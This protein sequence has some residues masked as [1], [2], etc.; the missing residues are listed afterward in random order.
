MVED[1][2]TRNSRPAQK[3]AMIDRVS[4]FVGQRLPNLERQ[5]QQAVWNGVLLLSIGIVLSVLGIS[6]RQDVVR[7]GWG[8]RSLTGF[9]HEIG[10]AYEA[11]LHTMQFSGH[12]HSSPAVVLENGRPLGPGNAQHDDVRKQGGG[13]FSFWG[14]WVYVSTS[15]NSDPRSNGRTYVAYGPGILST[16]VRRMTYASALT[17]LFLAAVCITIGLRDWRIPDTDRGWRSALRQELRRDASP[18]MPVVAVVGAFGVATTVAAIY[19]SVYYPVSILTTAVHVQ[20]HVIARLLLACGGY[21]IARATATRRG[22]GQAAVS[23]SI[24]AI[25]AIALLCHPQSGVGLDRHLLLQTDIEVFVLIGIALG[26]LRASKSGG[27]IG[28][29]KDSR[30]SRGAVVIASMALAIPGIALPVVNWW[31]IS[32]YMDSQMYD[33]D[34][35]R[36]ALGTALEGDSFVMPLY[37][38]GMAALYFVFGHFFYVQQIANVVLTLAAVV[39]L[40]LAAFELF[41][42][43]RAAL[44]MGVL[45]ALTPQFSSFVKITQVENWY[46]PLIALILYLWT[47]Y[48]NHPTMGRAVALAVAVGL[49]FN[50]RSQGTFFFGM[51]CLAPMW[52]PRVAVRRKLFQSAA[53]FVIVGLTLVPWSLRNYLYE[54]H[55][56]PSSDQATIGLLFNDHRVGFYGIRWDLYGWQQV[57]KEYEQR[58]PDKTERFAAIRHD[59]IGNTFGDPAWLARA[60]SWRTLSFYGLLPPGV[61][62]ASGP[63]PTNW[64]SEWPSYVY[65]GI[66]PLSL[67]AISMIGALR[68]LN[69]DTAFLAVCILATLAVMVFASQREA[70]ISYPV[71][72]L[73]IML[74]LAAMFPLSDRSTL[75]P[76]RIIG[77]RRLDWRIFAIGFG[78]LL[79]VCG[80]ARLS[81]GR[82][83]ANRPLMEHAMLVSESAFQEHRVRSPSY[84]DVNIEETLHGAT[85]VAGDAVRIRCRLTNYMLPPKSAGAVDYLP[86]YVSDP[87]REQYFFAH[88]VDGRRYL[89]ITYF[90]AVAKEVLRENDLVIV[91]GHV[92]AGDPSPVINLAFWLRADAV[93]KE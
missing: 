52:Q 14:D 16:V 30:V 88:T 39:L 20:V 83:N 25:V 91:E 6:L 37:Q 10:Y 36:I 67:I 75:V 92:L 23:A 26:L 66:V 29:W 8:Q 81:V 63:V 93:F 64:Q 82:E 86:A 55:F 84:R 89:G 90:G 77:E 22:F 48:R 19:L 41:R 27:R 58:I 3:H 47:R 53:M 45:V 59:A 74:G 68:R 73:H 12:Q 13:R 15:D 34:A 85:P 61:W 28:R 87:S 2:G 43:V 42:D 76:E 11:P 40:V 4:Y 5:P 33:V 24:L 72:P 17:T 44:L 18:I 1:V 54:G 78:S 9:V 62:N 38:Y 65:N 32:G 31:D 71:L 70:R 79:L 51:M 56:S 21:L 35:H 69:R 46:I 50:C 57:L 49:A 60:F 7:I 80:C